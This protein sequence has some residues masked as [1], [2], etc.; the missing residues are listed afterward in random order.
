MDRESLLSLI[1]E[2]KAGG[3]SEEGV[4]ERLASLPYEDLEFAKVDHHRALR[5]GFPEVIFCQG[6][7]PFQVREIALKIVERG[8]NLLATRATPEMFAQLAESLPGTRYNEAARTIT[9]I[10]SEIKILKGRVMIVTAGTSDLPV[11]QEAL[12]TGRMLGLDAS[13]VSDIGVAGIHRLLD[14]RDALAR[15]ALVIVVAGMEGALPSVV[16]GLI[17]CPVIAVPTS[18]GYGASFGGITP[19]LGMLNACVPGVAVMNIDNGFGAAFLAFRMLSMLK[20][21]LDEG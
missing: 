12:E 21:I 7:T 1:R 11:A 6:K 4:L 3:I 13:L 5:W 10:T 19:L 15:A 16:A 17:S 14:H 20:R 18:V 8:A 2:F 9:R